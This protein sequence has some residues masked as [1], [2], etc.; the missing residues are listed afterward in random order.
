[1][2]ASPKCLVLGLG[3]ALV[4]DD[5]IGLRVAAAARQE[6]AQL[7]SVTVLEAEEVGLA[8]LDLVVGFDRLLLVDA[9]QTGKAVPGSVHEWESGANN[10][11]AALSPHFLGIGEVLAMGRELGLAVPG[12]VKIFAVEVQD[13]FT[14][15]TRMTPVL[16]TALPDIVRR[17]VA[18][19][20]AWATSAPSDR[21]PS[22]GIQGPPPK[23]VQ[24]EFSFDS[25]QEE[26]GYARWLTGRK[27]AAQELARR[28]NLPLGHE[29]E[30][31]LTGGIRL[32]GTL[33]LREEV[34]FIE[35]DRVRHLELTVDHVHFTFREMESCLRLD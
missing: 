25:G 3:N 1:M 34:L 26:Q 2:K 13:P 11:I 5:A 18:S 30:V 20:R 15:G 22:P 35:E 24:G 23:S 14:L 27:M 21:S 32:R 31:W 29:V 7:P 6:L 16:E 12:Q 10:P 9:I 8:L 19:T 28:I 17:V 33:R 4:S